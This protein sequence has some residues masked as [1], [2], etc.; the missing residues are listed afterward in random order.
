MYLIYVHSVG[1]KR[2]NWLQECT[3][4]KASEV[5]VNLA[6]HHSVNDFG[7]RMLR[8]RILIGCKL[9]EHIY[10]TCNKLSLLLHRASCRFTIYHTTNKC[11]NCM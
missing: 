8:L 9:T 7:V 6:E 3:E 5:Y 1:I 4:L 2:R 10:L 11:T